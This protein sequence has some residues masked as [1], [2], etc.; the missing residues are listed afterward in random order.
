MAQSDL[1]KNQKRDYQLYLVEDGEAGFSPE[2]N[3]YV[4]EK[5]IKE[6]EA[7]RKRRMKDYQDNL[8]ERTDAV[9]TF[10]TSKFAQYSAFPNIE[11]YFG[12]QYLAHLRGEQIA[13]QLKRQM[14]MNKK[15]DE[16]TIKS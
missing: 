15:I 1:T 16:L 5:S 2:R 12:R 4:I 11:K 7:M 6:Y 9:A 13:Q 14:L 3:K 8:G 10:L